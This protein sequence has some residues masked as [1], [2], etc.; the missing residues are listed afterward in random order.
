MSLQ[1]TPPGDLSPGTLLHQVDDFSVSAVDQP[2]CMQIITEIGRHLK[3]PLND[4]GIIRKFNGANILQTRWFIRVSCED[5]LTKILTN[6]DWLHLKASHQS[7]PMRSDPQYQRQLELAPRPA[8]PEEQK[9]V[10]AQAGF[11]YRMAMGNLFTP[12]LLRAQRFPLPLP[13]SEGGFGDYF[14][15]CDIDQNLVNEL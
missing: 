5:Y 13:T 6:H 8:T 12:L 11:S 3:A 10:Q 9:H 15:S 4:L 1:Q 14:F 7:L 2:S